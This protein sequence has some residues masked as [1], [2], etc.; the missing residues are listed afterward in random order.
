MLCSRKVSKLQ[1]EN[2]A[3]RAD[4]MR[5]RW[6]RDK[7]DFVRRKDGSPQVCITDEWG[8]IV[9]VQASAYPQGAVLD[10]AIDAAM[11]ESK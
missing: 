4:A 6:L 8:E 3:L 10:A 11:K 5:Y 1:A 9:S 2:E 7:A